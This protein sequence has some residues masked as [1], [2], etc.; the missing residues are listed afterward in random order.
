MATNLIQSG[1]RMTYAN[2]T[3]SDISSGDLVPVGATFGVA[4]GDIDNGDSGE[5]IMEG[6]FEIPADDSAAISQGNPVYYVASTGE[7]SPTAEDQKY[8]GIAWAAK[9][10]TG[11][12]VKVKIGC[13]YHPTVN[14]V[15]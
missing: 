7:A 15:A 13:G 9:A 4:V 6:V 3:G 11:T 14:N 2:A 5:L 1:A 12:T 8:I 10:E